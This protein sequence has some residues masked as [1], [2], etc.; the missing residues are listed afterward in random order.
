[1]FTANKLAES[2]FISYLKDRSF[3]APVLNYK[4]NPHL[5]QVDGVTRGDFGIHADRNVPGTAGCIGIESERDWED[6]KGIM[7]DYHHAG[8]TSIPL[9]V[10]YR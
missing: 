9:L 3:R 5:I 2:R 10:S 4:I 6:F 7:D 8:L 1:M